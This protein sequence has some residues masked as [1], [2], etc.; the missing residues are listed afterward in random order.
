ML[1]NH[2]T[3]NTASTQDWLQASRGMRISAFDPNTVDKKTLILVETQLEA[4]HVNN[5]TEPLF[6]THIRETVQTVKAWLGQK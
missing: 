5:Q 1:I 3:T 6:G 4:E 2:P